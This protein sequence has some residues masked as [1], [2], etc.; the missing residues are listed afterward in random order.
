[1]KKNDAFKRYIP[2]FDHVPHK[3][4]GL[5]LHSA[6]GRLYPVVTPQSISD[7]QK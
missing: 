7:N 2:Y 3:L 4:I 1:M 5:L 6:Y